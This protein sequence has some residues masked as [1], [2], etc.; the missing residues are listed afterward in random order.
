VAYREYGLRANEAG[1]Y[2]AWL[3]AVA[4][5]YPDKSPREILNDLVGQ[6]PGDEGKWF[7]A[8]KSLEFFDEAI[9][10]ARQSQVT[11]ACRQIR[12]IAVQRPDSLASAGP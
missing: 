7:A 1:T 3:R 11:S 2:L 10:L 4:K 9:E 5:K 12:A 6:T 8:A